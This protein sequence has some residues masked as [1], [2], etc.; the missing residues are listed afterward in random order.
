LWGRVLKL[1]TWHTSVIASLRASAASW[2]A[3]LYWERSSD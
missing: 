1:F 3:W 2:S